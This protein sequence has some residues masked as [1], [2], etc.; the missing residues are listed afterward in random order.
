MLAEEKR[1]HFYKT[2]RTLT[3]PPLG[4]QQQIRKGGTPKG[5]TKVNPPTKN[6]GI[7]RIGRRKG[8]VS[9]GISLSKLERS[10]EM[11]SRREK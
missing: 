8:A 1:K 5:K 2:G 9:W 3:E 11:N 4:H 6:G 7:L 10:L